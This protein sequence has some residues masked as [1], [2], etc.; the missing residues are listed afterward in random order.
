VLR[1][2]TIK[3]PPP[4]LSATVRLAFATTVFAA[5]ACG[6][7]GTSGDPAPAPEQVWLDRVGSGPSQTARVCAKGAR[8]RVAQAL[9]EPSAASISGLEDVYAALRLSSR[10]QRR[11]A[12]TTHSLSLSGR[13]VSAAN[14]RVMVLANNDVPNGLSYEGVVATAFVRGEQ[15]VELVGLDPVTYEYN[16]Y[17]LRFAQACNDSRCTPEDLLSERVESGWTDWT[18]YADS[19]LEDTPFDC[20]SCH[21][22]FG[23]GTLKLLLMRQVLDPWMHW[24]DFRVFDENLCPTSPPEGVAPKVI[25]TSDGLDLV[26]RLAGEHGKYAGVPLEELL[27]SKSGD[28]L[29]DFMVDAE[30]LIAESPLPPHPYAQLSLQTRETLCERFYT[31]QSPSWEVDKLTA[32]ARGLPFPYYGPEVL[33]PAARSELLADPANFWARRPQAEPFDVLAALLSADVPSAVG[34]APRE[35]DSAP[36]IL[37]GMCGRCHAA[38]ANPA[39][40]RSRFN[41]EDTGSVS[42][43]TFHQVRARLALPATSPDAMP[44]RLAG[45]LPAWAKDRILDYLAARC[46][47]PGACR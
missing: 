12:A 4:R 29:S 6:G 39:F 2:T 18:L 32:Q 13:R 22:P 17:L 23:E 21:R 43:S 40:L 31:G 19:D 46:A 44:P 26:A 30:N 47:T 14:P 15:A 35:S 28:V 16:F 36:D 42:P 3:P 11:L 24:S 7:K 20:L 38:D 9:C 27:A 34:F 25:A 1:S 10:D 45:T 33:D 37:R 5:L 41:A 8:D